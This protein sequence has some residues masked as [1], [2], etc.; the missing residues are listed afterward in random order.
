VLKARRL[1]ELL[2]PVPPSAGLCA[3]VS[4]KHSQISTEKAHGQPNPHPRP[5]PRA[6][7]SR[8]APQPTRALL[9]R[10]LGGGRSG[11][12][13]RPRAAAWPGAPLPQLPPSALLPPPSQPRRAPARGPEPRRRPGHR[14]FSGA[15]KS[16]GLR[17]T[18]GGVERTEL[19]G[20][21]GC[22]FS[23][24]PAAATCGTSCMSVGGPGEG[25]RC[26]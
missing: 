24:R 26:W 22:I 25:A 1:L 10:R 16:R 8:R 21:G 13:P 12:H 14:V 15:G 5:C 18:W 3:R 23:S 4:S 20:K 2:M 7:S 19:V 9:G 17:V 11:T 6:S